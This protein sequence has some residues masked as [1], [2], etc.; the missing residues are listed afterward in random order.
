MVLQLYLFFI[1]TF[2]FFSKKLVVLF[3]NSMP[4]LI[5]QRETF[6]L[7]EILYPIAKLG[8]SYKQFF[9]LLPF[10]LLAFLI[11]GEKRFGNVYRY[12]FVRVS[13]LSFGL[14][15]FFI[16]FENFS[17]LLQRLIVITTQMLF[18]ELCDHEGEIRDRNSF[19]FYTLDIF[20]LDEGFD[21]ICKTPKDN[22]THSEPGLHETVSVLSR[23]L[24]E[25][26]APSTNVT[27]PTLPS[28]T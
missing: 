18:R 28:F 25:D 14:F 2:E 9:L 3:I 5:I 16:L 8:L 27:E 15:V 11:V 22:H 13:T 7:P 1:G 20:F 21:Y 6:I 23:I 10:F 19:S 12:H 24:L 26:F 17:D 4:R